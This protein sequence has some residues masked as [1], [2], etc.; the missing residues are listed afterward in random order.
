MTI[1]DWIIASIPILN[2]IGVVYV[3]VQFILGI[4]ELFGKRIHLTAPFVRPNHVRWD[5]T[6]VALTGVMAAVVTALAVIL[7]AFPIVPGLPAGH[8][9]WLAYRSLEPIFSICFGVPTL[10]AFAIANTLIDFFTGSLHFWT[11]T[12]VAYALFFPMLLMRW[13]GNNPYKSLTTKKGLAGYG[14]WLVVYNITKLFGPAT[15]ATLFKLIPGEIA[16]TM[17]GM[18]YGLFGNPLMTLP[19]WLGFLIVTPILFKALP[20]ILERYG[21]LAMQR[22]T[23]KTD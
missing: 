6:D 12:G 17:F 1:Y 15:F 3:A 19:N 22:H 10:I 8:W 23:A 13:S 7:A 11:I 2:I 20:P 5:A 4:P 21:L 9:G 14:A 18:A 16:W